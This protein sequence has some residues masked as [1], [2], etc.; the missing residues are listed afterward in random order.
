MTIWKYELTDMKT[1]LTMPKDGVVLDVQWQ[2][3]Q[4]VMWVLLDP[5]GEIATREFRIYGT[6]WE[7]KEE[8]HNYITTLQCGE[9]VWHIFERT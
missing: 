5:Q 3:C 2:G 8:P 1:H 9:L 6:G 4:I 7:C